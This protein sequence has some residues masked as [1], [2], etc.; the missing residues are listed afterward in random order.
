MTR[1]PYDP[2]SEGAQMN[3]REKMSYG[4]YLHLDRLLDAQSPR[5]TAA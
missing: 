1:A 3:F 5:S 4:D 2:S